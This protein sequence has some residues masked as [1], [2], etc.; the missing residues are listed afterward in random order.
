MHI[1]NSHYVSIDAQNRVINGFSDAFEAPR[2]DSICISDQGG[3]Q[4]RLFVDGEENPSLTDSVGAHLWY[5]EN[6]SVRAATE[7]ELEAERAEI[8]ANAPPPMPSDAQR[9]ATLE[10]ELNA[11]LG[12][13]TESKSEGETV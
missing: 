13:E 2:E 3:Y 8:A 11:L 9:L 7:A 6:G 1:Y 12:L 5:W 4:F 10:A